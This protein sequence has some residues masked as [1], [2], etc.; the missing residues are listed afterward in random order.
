MESEGLVLEIP[1]RLENGSCHPGGDET[2]S[3]VG[4]SKTRLGVVVVYKVIC[5]YTKPH[6]SKLNLYRI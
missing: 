4:R 1:G 5:G 6:N 3:W 2:A